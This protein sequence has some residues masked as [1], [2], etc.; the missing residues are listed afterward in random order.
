MFKHKDFHQCFICTS[1]NL[2]AVCV[3]SYA[4]LL[5]TQWAYQA[6]LST[7]FPRQEYWSGLSCP[8]AGDPPYSGIEPWS[9]TSPALQVDSL[10]LSNL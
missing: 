4:Q 5:V 7:G 10:L 3:L 6:P 9:L 8:P 1:K 2:C